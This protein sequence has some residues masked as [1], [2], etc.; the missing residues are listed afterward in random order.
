[1]TAR[2]LPSGDFW[3]E[4]LYAKNYVAT[5]YTTIGYGFAHPKNDV[6]RIA[7]I[8]ISIIGYLCGYFKSYFR[9]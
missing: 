1:M 2:N 5:L 4:F 6:G 7:T 9:G 3:V 8:L